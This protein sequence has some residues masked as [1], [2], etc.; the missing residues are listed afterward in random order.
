MGAL[1]A[2]ARL[3]NASHT[4]YAIGGPWVSLMQFMDD[5]AQRLGRVPAS[6]A[7]HR[8]AAV[9]AGGAQGTHVAIDPCHASACAIAASTGM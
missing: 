2:V 9:Q 3:Q 4:L 6:S 8:R 1:F 5:L 7:T